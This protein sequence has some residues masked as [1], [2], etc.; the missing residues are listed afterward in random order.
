MND[1]HRRIL[2]DCGL[3][4]NS[5]VLERFVQSALRSTGLRGEV[6]VWIT[7]SA[8]IRRL[9]SFFRG[10]ASATDVLSFPAAQANGLVGDI[11]I[12]A[13]IAQRNARALGHSL[14]DEIRILILHAI[15][16]LAGYDHE[17]DRGEMAQKEAALR[18]KFGLPTGLIERSVKRTAPAPGRRSSSGISRP[19]R[20]TRDPRR[21][22]T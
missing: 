12:S 9:N 22:R 16:H 5:G 1:G 8:Q 20:S 11:A 18:K 7:G 21:Q 3:D 4:L 14:H 17:K 19:R 6:S 13:E 2:C 10:K 15:L